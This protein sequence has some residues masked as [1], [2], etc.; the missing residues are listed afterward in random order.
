MPSQIEVK[1]LSVWWRISL[2]HLTY[3]KLPCSKKILD[4]TNDEYYISGAIRSTPLLCLYEVAFA[5]EV[6]RPSQQRTKPPRFFDELQQFEEARGWL[7]TVDH[8]QK[9]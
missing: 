2:N 5:V 6:A 7:Y 1:A 4:F 3:D 8:Q 9:G